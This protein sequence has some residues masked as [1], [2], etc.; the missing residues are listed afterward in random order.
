MKVFVANNSTGDNTPVTVEQSATVADA[1]RKAGITP[2]GNITVRKNR[3]NCTLSDALYDGDRI[4]VTRKDLKGAAPDAAPDLATALQVTYED[5]VN[6]GK[7]TPG[8]ANAVVAKAMQKHAEQS[9]EK[10]VKVIGGLL[11]E[12][13]DEGPVVNRAVAEAEAALAEAKDNQA[14]FEYAFKRLADSGNIFALLGFL[15]RKDEAA[16]ICDQL[17]CAVPPANS[18]LW[19][20]SEN[21]K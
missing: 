1:L 7:A 19:H 17:G 14:R 15:G 2:D 21:G 12:A 9:N 18:P 6:A 11:S 4:S 13:R 16:F 5:I 20:T 8:V 10:L 3:E